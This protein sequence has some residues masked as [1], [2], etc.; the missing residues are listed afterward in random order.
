MKKLKS[1]FLS[2]IICMSFVSGRG[3]LKEGSF[4]SDDEMEDIVSGYLKDLFRV[5]GIKQKPN[6]YFLVSPEINAAASIGFQM[7]IFTGFINKCENASQ[8]L[9]VLAH[10][11]GHIA[12]GHPSLSQNAVSEST[13]PALIA[14]ALGG[15]AAI[16]GGGGDMLMAGMAAGATIFERGLLKFSR[17]QEESADSAA[18]SYLVQLGWPVSGLESFLRLLDRTFSTGQEDLYL[19]THP[20]TP[21]RMDKI[22]IFIEEKNYTG[23][24]PEAYEMKFKRLKAKVKAFTQAPQQTL[25]DYSA[26]DTSL[27]ANYARA[28]AY[29]RSGNLA[30][31]DH[32]L[33]KLMKNNSQDT[34]F[35]ELRGQFAFESGKLDKALSYFKKAYQRPYNSGI[36]LMYAHCM[37]EASSDLPKAIDFLNKSIKKNPD[38][39]FAWRLMAKAYGTMG[40]TAD[41]AGALAEEAWLMK[42]YNL[43]KR[44]AKTAKDATNPQ[45]K[46]RALDIL[47]MADGQTDGDDRGDGRD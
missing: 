42:N 6:I 30:E 1:I 16:A 5:A 4:V 38:N 33:E 41:A 36:L 9:G 14:T 8:F 32:I 47:S 12:G 34:Y 44:H 20:L 43:A 3:E 18:I 28:I 7:I 31:A 23:Q 39:I 29:Y 10:E 40:K 26:K 21:D 19:Q 2:L 24:L 11:T 46:K 22:K 15:V 35:A 37:I 27:D 45:I 13:I 17:G 25:R